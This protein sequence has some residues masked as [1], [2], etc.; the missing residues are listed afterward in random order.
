MV[1]GAVMFGWKP[2]FVKSRKSKRTYGTSFVSRFR[3][4]VDPERLMFYGDDNVK[5]CSRRFAKLVSVNQE[6]EIDH[7][8]KSSYTPSYHNILE[9]AINVYESEKNDVTYCDE[10]GV[11]LLGTIS[12]PMTNTTGDM[13]REVRVTV[14]F[15]RTEIIVSGKDLTSGANVQAAFDFL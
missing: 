9:M 11:R 5:W 4:N 8:V 10:P 1:Q 13:N 14:C 7:T 6:I 12:V 3:Q 15:G 2:K